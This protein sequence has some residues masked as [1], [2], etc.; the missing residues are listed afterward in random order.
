MMT[1]ILQSLY[2]KYKKINILTYYVSCLNKDASALLKVMNI[3][4]SS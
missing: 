2:C 3:W 4:T 1:D